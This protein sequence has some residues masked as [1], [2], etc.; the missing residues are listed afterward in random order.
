M[1]HKFAS[2]LVPRVI[3]AVI[4]ALLECETHLRQRGIGSYGH[5]RLCSQQPPERTVL[6]LT[7]STIP[8]STLLYSTLLYPSLLYHAIYTMRYYTVRYC[9]ERYVALLN[10]PLAGETNRWDEGKRRKCPLPQSEISLLSSVGEREMIQPKHGS[11]T[12][13]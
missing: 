13:F 8:Y 1:D 2:G 11:E 12:T 7:N 3:V 10:P 9:E 4:R 5:S 6:Y